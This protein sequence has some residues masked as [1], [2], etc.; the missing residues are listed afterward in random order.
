MSAHG[1][2]PKMTGFQRY[3]VSDL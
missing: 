3:G 1:E 2:V